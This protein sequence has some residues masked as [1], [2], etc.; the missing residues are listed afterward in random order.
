MKYIFWTIFCQIRQLFHYSIRL[1]LLYKRWFCIK[2]F[3]VS[4]EC[5]KKSVF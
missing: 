1:E 2:Y 4:S 3:S 5:F